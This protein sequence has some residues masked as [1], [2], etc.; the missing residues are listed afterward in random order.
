[1]NP[2][3]GERPLT[4]K[5]FAILST[6]FCSTNY[7]DAAKLSFICGSWHPKL[8]LT[9]RLLQL[10]LT[11]SPVCLIFSARLGL[12]AAESKVSK[13]P[14]EPARVLTAESGRYSLPVST[15]L[16][17]YNLDITDRA[18]YRRATG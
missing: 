12:K 2:R 13:Y 15:G 18:A 17:A 14:C 6:S 9:F 10:A 16:D 5:T 4:L 11:L 3:T 1:M 8:T 7:D